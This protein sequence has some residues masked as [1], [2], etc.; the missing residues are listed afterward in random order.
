MKDLSQTD[1]LIQTGTYNH[2]ENLIDF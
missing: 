2:G 1:S